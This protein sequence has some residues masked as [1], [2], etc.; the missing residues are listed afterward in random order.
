VEVLQEGL[1]T[2]WLARGHDALDL[3]LVFPGKVVGGFEFLCRADDYGWVLLGA[4][5]GDRA[6]G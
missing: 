1:Q 4:R 2:D 6:D 5:V 3:L